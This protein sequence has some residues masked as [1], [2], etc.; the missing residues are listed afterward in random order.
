MAKMKKEK[1]VVPKLEDF[2][3]PSDEASRKRI[4]GCVNEIILSLVRQDGEKDFVKEAAEALEEELAVPKKFV[5]KLA[6]VLHKRGLAEMEA[7]TDVLAESATILVGY[8]VNP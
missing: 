8:G 4:A 1:V 6:K 5:T 7:Q 2:V 3:L